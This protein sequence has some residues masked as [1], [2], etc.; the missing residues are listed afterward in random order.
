MI[1]EIV[2]AGIF[3]DK[4]QSFIRIKV[5]VSRNEILRTMWRYASSRDVLE[6]LALLVDDGTIIEACKGGKVVYQMPPSA[7]VV[8][9]ATP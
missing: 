5:C 7:S 9:G 3:L 6:G 4:L 2:E 8:G 1:R